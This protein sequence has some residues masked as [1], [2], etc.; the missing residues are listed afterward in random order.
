M[1]YFHFAYLTDYGLKTHRAKN[2]H[3][4]G[5]TYT[6]E[7]ILNLRSFQVLY[8]IPPNSQI[9]KHPILYLNVLDFDYIGGQ[10][11]PIDHQ[12][13]DA[14]V[15]AHFATWRHNAHRAYARNIAF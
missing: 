9:H 3:P 15:L 6:L 8:G 4:R 2:A 14:A 1:C 12:S 11:E 7:S 13:K 10:A 5:L